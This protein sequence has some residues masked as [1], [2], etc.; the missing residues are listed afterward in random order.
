MKKNKNSTKKI[1]SLKKDLE[2]IKKSFLFKSKNLVLFIILVFISWSIVYFIFYFTL[3]KVERSSLWSTELKPMEKTIGWQTYKNEKYGFEIDYP[4]NVL[5][6]IIDNGENVGPK[7]IQEE[8]D[9]SLDSKSHISVYI[10]KADAVISDDSWKTE[11]Y[12]K[13]TLN[14]KVALQNIKKQDNNFYSARTYQ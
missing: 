4:D 9:F 2:E 11:N 5:Y 1:I 6:F 8:I 12:E 14:N 10:W 7:G 13:L 3:L